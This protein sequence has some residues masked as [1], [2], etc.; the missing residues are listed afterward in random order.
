MSTITALVITKN[1]EQHIKAC[2]E[3]SKLVADEIIIF[4]SNSTDK[5]AEIATS[6]GAKVINCDNFDGF[7]PQRQKAQKHA[8][9][10]WCFWLDADERVTYELAKEIKN[11][12]NSAKDNEVLAIPRANHCFGKL[13]KYSGWSP[14]FVLRVHKRTYT[15]YNNSLVHEKLELKPDSKIVKCQKKLTHFTYLSYESM[16]TK[17]VKYSEIWA[18]NKYIKTNKTCS[19]I[20]PIIKAIGNFFINY[21]IRLGFLDGR[22]GF[23]LCVVS[24]FYTFNKYANWY[25]MKYKNKMDSLIKEP[26][27]EQ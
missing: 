15:T 11:F 4:D 16:L 5:T 25:C 10:E 8:T 24:S 13:I 3:S 17:N 7:G 22:L 12:V 23:I 21:F 6:L 1:E 2:V 9:Q 14:D 19:F 26:P 20:T 18:S 27:K